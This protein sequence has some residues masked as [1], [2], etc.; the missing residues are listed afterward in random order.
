VPFVERRNGFWNTIHSKAMWPGF[1]SSEKLLHTTPGFR[2]LVAIILFFFEGSVPITI[3]QLPSMT[4]CVREKE[5]QQIFYLYDNIPLQLGQAVIVSHYL[6]GI[7][8][9]GPQLFRRMNL[10]VSLAHRKNITATAFFQSADAVHHAL[11]YHTIDSLLSQLSQSIASEK[12]SD[13]VNIK[14]NDMNEVT[15]AFVQI[16]YISNKQRDEVPSLYHYLTPESDNELFFSSLLTHMNR[17]MSPVLWPKI[18]R[19]LQPNYNF[20][21]SMRDIHF[22]AFFHS[23]RIDLS[24]R[25]QRLTSP[26][27]YGFISTIH[28]GFKCHIALNISFVTNDSEQHFDRSYLESKATLLRRDLISLFHNGESVLTNFDERFPNALIDVTIAC[29]DQFEL[30]ADDISLLN[31][32]SFINAEDDDHLMKYFV[33][34]IEYSE[35][36]E[37]LQRGHFKEESEQ[38]ERTQQFED[39]EMSEVRKGLFNSSSFNETSTCNHTTESFDLSIEGNRSSSSTLPL[40][41]L[42]FTSLTSKAFVTHFTTWKQNMKTIV[43][44]PSNVQKAIPIAIQVTRNYRDPSNSIN[45]KKTVPFY[46]TTCIQILEELTV[47]GVFITFLMQLAFVGLTIAVL[48]FLF[49]LYLILGN[50]IHIMQLQGASLPSFVHIYEYFVPLYFPYIW[51]PSPQLWTAQQNQRRTEAQ[52]LNQSISPTRTQPSHQNS[53]NVNDN[54]GSNY[55]QQQDERIQ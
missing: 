14:A 10:T 54:G 18:S 26:N 3:V 47:P 43:T 27:K 45:Y 19:Y 7:L 17:G 9:L 37:F 32:M 55:E 42:H 51:F 31:D 12:D 21:I 16:P 36:E 25:N 24:L 5:P 4:M 28:Y 23:F 39:N 13:S 46:Q 15:S 20:S 6:N 41:T 34:S 35:T 53:N 29:T 48:F 1:V 8:T 44:S 38:N 40:E 33:D 2:F 22:A 52:P 11:Y 49:S 30:L 50:T